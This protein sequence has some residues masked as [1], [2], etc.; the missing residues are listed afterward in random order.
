MNKT[1]GDNGIP[2]ELFKILKYGGLQELHLTRQQILKTQQWSQDCKM[3]VFIPIPKKGHVK[4]ISNYNTIP[5]LSH[6]SKIMPQILKAQLQNYLNQEL[7]DVQDRFR[8]GR[9]TRDQIANNRW[10]IEKNKRISGKRLFLL[11]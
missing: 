4:E 3:S 10:I 1:S 8:K 2:G 9:I 5:F 6:A 11:H 7:P